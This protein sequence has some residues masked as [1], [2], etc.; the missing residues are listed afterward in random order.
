VVQGQKVNK[1]QPKRCWS[2]GRASL[3][4]EAA[5]RSNNDEQLENFNVKNKNTKHCRFFQVLGQFEKMIIMSIVEHHS[6]ANYKKP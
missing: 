4:L 3:F 5:C 6:T 1:K 2:L